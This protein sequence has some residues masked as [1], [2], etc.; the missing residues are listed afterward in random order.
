MAIEAGD[1]IRS[2][3]GCGIYTRHDGPTFL[4]HPTHELMRNTLCLVVN[5]VQTPILRTTFYEVLVS[6]K[7]YWVIG[8]ASSWNV[9][10]A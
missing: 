9:V 7:T 1:L 10:S 6:G 5:V 4:I 2:R 8:N 3:N